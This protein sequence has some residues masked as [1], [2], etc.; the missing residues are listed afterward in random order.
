[1][2]IF[3]KVSQSHL[4]FQH[5][6][7]TKDYKKLFRPGCLQKLYRVLQFISVNSEGNRGNLDNVLCTLKI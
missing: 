1:L 6:D 4:Y 3:Q 2:L 7:F 5:I